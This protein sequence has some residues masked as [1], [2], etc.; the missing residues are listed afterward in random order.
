M[1]NPKVTA[2]NIDKAIAW[3]EEHEEAIAAAL[4]IHVP[5]ILYKPGCQQLLASK[6][7]DWRKGE[8]PLNLADCYVRKPIRDFYRAISIRRPKKSLGKPG[9]SLLSRSSRLSREF[10][11]P[12][13]KGF[14]PIAINHLRPDLQ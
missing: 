9:N 11:I 10:W 4:P 6:I 3:Y 14:G 7:A 2:E 12:P 13:L 8:T 1:E 5:G